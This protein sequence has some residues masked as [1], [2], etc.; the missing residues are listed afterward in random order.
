M[1]DPLYGYQKMIWN[2]SPSIVLVVREKL[3]LTTVNSLG[4]L[5]V[6]MESVRLDL[7]YFFA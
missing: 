7:S 2:Y 1:M 6:F 3:P 4:C 5:C